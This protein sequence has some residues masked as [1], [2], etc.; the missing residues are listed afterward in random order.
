MKTLIFGLVAMLFAVTITSCGDESEDPTPV[1][2]TKKEYE[3]TWKFVQAVVVKTG[4]LE[5]KTITSIC[6]GTASEAFGTEFTTEYIVKA[7]LKATQKSP[8]LGDAEIRYVATIENDKL[9]AIQFYEDFNQNG[10]MDGTGN[11][12]E[13]THAVYYDQLVFDVDAKTVK[14][15]QRTFGKAKTITTTFKLQ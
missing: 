1:T 5:T 7:D 8:C 4:G 2:P 10:V 15:N 11:L 3:G 12:D 13:K 9:T 6:S 14:G